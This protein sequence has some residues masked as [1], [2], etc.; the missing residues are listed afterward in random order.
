MRCYNC[1]KELRIENALFCPFCGK[2][3][4]E[5]NA[6][7]RLSAGTVLHDRYLVG[8]TLGEG[9]FGIT[10]VGFDTTLQMKVA[11]KEYYPSGIA[12]R[13][14]TVSNTVSVGV[15]KQKNIFDSGKDS[16]LNE[17]RSVA[18]FSKERGIVDVRDFFTEN[19]TAYIVM[20]FLDGVNLNEYIYKNGVI[21]AKQTFEMMLPLMRSL[22][23]MHKQNVIHRD[24]SPDNIMRQNDG[25]LKLMDFGSA[26]QY[27]REGSVSLSVVLKPCY[28]P[29]E[30]Y[31]RKGK[32]GPWTDVYAL[33]ATIYK[34]ITG[35]TPP[36]SLDRAIEDDLKKPSELGISIPESLENA[37]MKGLAVHSQDR[38]QSMNELIA[39]IEEKPE[40]EKKNPEIKKTENKTIAADDIETG[41]YISITADDNEI[42]NSNT[43]ATDDTQID[44][45]RT[46]AANFPYNDPEKTVSAEGF[47]S[48]V[49][50][51]QRIPTYGDSSSY[52]R[53]VA[54]AQNNEVLAADK[55]KKGKSVTETIIGLVLLF[56]LICAII[57]F[58]MTQITNCSKEK[59]KEKTTAVSIPESI[60]FN[61]ESATATI[62]PLTEDPNRD[63]TAEID[64]VYD[65]QKTFSIC[66]NRFGY[67]DSGGNAHLFELSETGVRQISLN[68]ADNSDLSV[69][70]CTEVGVVAVKKNG[71]PVVLEKSA[72]DVDYLQFLSSWSGLADISI[73]PYSLTI[74]NKSQEPYFIVD[75]VG[76]RKDGTAISARYNNKSGFNFDDPLEV[77]EWTNIKSI[78]WHWGITPIGLKSNGTPMPEELYK[79]RTDIASLGDGE[80]M[81][82]KNGTTYDGL[83]T[84]S[85]YLA[86]SNGYGLK[87]DGTVKKL[88]PSS[89]PKKYNVSDWS[90]ITAIDSDQNLMVG[91]KSDGTFILASGSDTLNRSFDSVVNS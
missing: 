27:S 86:V 81:I 84:N 5:Q 38:L 53:N 9:G 47:T 21:E 19:N 56:S 66:S 35:Q 1:M 77:N 34:C 52:H 17:A 85:H 69:I 75:A 65:L 88:T 46:L 76:L 28:A 15:E 24:I 3:P 68:S 44:D 89:Q 7:H 57:G 54:S 10:Y 72:D 36:D 80:I 11:L 49:S 39:A 37:L 64:A 91:K 18:Q 67:I 59:G 22:Q 74:R 31:S 2:N 79:N 50:S 55:P 58:I 51:P 16:F 33:C 71:K 73:H 40:A 70:C 23:K 30:Q 63:L 25:T 8:A 83:T 26:R 87:T 4:K 45:N 12:A 82:K 78:S 32:Q 13:V 14:N 61:T 20:E 60:E 41:K 43:T 29:Y 48:A 42:D 62:P 6:L 90:G